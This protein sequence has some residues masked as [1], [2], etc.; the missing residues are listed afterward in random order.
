MFTPSHL[1]STPTPFTSSGSNYNFPQELLLHMHHN[2]NNTFN[3]QSTTY[4]T[5][6]ASIYSSSHNNINNSLLQQYQH[7]VLPNHDQY[8]LL[9]DIVPSMFLNRTNHN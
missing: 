6:N 3:N 5:S 4:A 2:N 8:G 9:Q 7:Q 1:L